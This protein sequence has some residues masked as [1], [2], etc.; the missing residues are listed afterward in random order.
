MLKSPGIPIQIGQNCS[1]PVFASWYNNIDCNNGRRVKK[2]EEFKAL[3]YTS[4]MASCND[5]VT[6]RDY[7]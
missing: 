5:Y 2:G 6:I 3:Y 1:Q 4:A 7:I